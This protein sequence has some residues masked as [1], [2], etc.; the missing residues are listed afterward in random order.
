VV[1]LLALMKIG[2]QVTISVQRVKI[3][4]APSYPRQHT[5]ALAHAR[6]RRGA[7]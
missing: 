6:V 2:A 7:A 4:F 5:F 1:T 3:A